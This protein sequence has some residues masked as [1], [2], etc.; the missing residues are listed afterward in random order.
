MVCRGMI[1]WYVVWDHLCVRNFED[2]LVFRQISTCFLYV[3]ILKR[4]CFLCWSYTVH[5][6][7]SIRSFQYIYCIFIIEELVYVWNPIVMFKDQITFYNLWSWFL[8]WCV[9]G[10]VCFIDWWLG[11][12]ED[13]NG[14]RHFSRRDSE[15][16]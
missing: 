10:F 16:S 3:V 7:I 2:I 14:P 5:V 8:T 6:C 9:Y 12:R 15:A 13:A 4:T 11:G 1:M